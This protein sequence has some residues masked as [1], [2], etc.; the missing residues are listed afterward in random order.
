MAENIRNLT[1]PVIIAMADL[2]VFVYTIPICCEA[3]GA[4]RYFMAFLFA[5][6]FA[7]IE[8]LA[9]IWRAAL[10]ALRRDQNAAP[11]FSESSDLHGNSSGGKFNV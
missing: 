10:P 5:L 3:W 6:I 11:I 9:N 4:N 2:V 1:I 7:W 8:S